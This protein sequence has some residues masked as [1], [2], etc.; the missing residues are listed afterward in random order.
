MAARTRFFRARSLIL[1]PSN[2]SIARHALPPRPALKSLSGS[3]RLAPWEKVSLTLS[4]WALP[5]A[6]IPSRDHTGL[7]IHFHSSII[8]RSASRMLLRILAN[9]LPRQS[10]SPAISWS[11]RSDGFIGSLYLQFLSRFHSFRKKSSND[12]AFPHPQSRKHKYRN[13]HKPGSGGVVWNLVKRT[14][15]ITGYRNGKDD[16]N[17]A[18][19]RTFGSFFHDLSSI[20]LRLLSRLG[21][22]VG[23][24]DTELLCVLD[25]QSL[26]AA[27][28]HG[29]GADDASNGSSAEKVIQNIETNVPPGS[30]HGDEAVT[31]VGPQRQ[32]C[33][34]TQVFEFPPHIEATPLVLQHLR[35]DGSRHGCFGN[36]RRGRSHRGELHRASNRSQAPIGVEGSPLAQMRRVGKSL[37]DFFRRVAQLSDENER[38]L[39]FLVIV[40]S[41]FLFYSCQVGRTRCVLLAIGHLRFLSAYSVPAV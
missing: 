14:I 10:V 34:A 24:F 35:S 20:Y 31:D 36:A 8:S 37:P 18:K 7:P 22:P 12:M 13:K 41:P 26:P 6:I 25:V 27:E 30:T 3:G 21:R 1:S 2:K 15:N 16:V 40:L 11:I 39:L 19:N 17:P 4:L 23:R 33:A 32:A 9:V 28:L 38:P 29:L 5:T